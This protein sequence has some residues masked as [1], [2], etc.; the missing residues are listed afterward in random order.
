MSTTPTV[1]W[2]TLVSC[3]CI[4]QPQEASAQQGTS[5]AGDSAL[6][7]ETDIDE[8]LD[9]ADEDFVPLAC[10]GSLCE[11]ATGSLCSLTQGRIP[12]GSHVGGMAMVAS[13]LLAT[14]RR[15]PTS[16]NQTAKSQR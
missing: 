1:Y 13:I 8:E 6:S 7:T 10:D 3:V 16:L 2:L 5:D 14:R 11:T 12:S 15:T 9:T 4:C